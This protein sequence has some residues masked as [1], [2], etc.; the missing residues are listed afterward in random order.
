MAF[1]FFLRKSGES[2]R[3]V[4]KPSNSNQSREESKKRILEAP[5]KDVFWVKKPTYDLPEKAKI[6]KNI[7]CDSCQEA[8]PE[9]KMG[10]QDGK[11]V[12][13]DCFTGYHRVW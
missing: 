1:S 8:S 7:V 3:I 13:S 4:L 12:C 6:F 9:Y 5:A 2:I 11:T 10:L